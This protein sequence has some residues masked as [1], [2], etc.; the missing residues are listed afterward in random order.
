M[1]GACLIREACSV[2]DIAEACGD[3]GG[4]D[5]VVF[6]VDNV[7][8][9]PADP[10]YQAP[11]LASHAGLFHAIKQTLNPL[12]TDIFL[13]LMITASASIFVEESMVS[14]LNS[15]HRRGIK[16]V[17]LTAA[18]TG[19]LGATSSMETW[20]LNEL[21]RLGIHFDRSFPDQ[22]K[23]LW[24]E[25]PA[26]RG[27]HAVFQEGVLFSNGGN[28][29]TTK[30]ELLVAFLEK[31]AFT[32]SRVVFVDDTLFHLKTVEKALGLSYPHTTYRGLH[33]QKATR[34]CPPKVSAQEFVFKM[35][36]LARQAQDAL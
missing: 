30:G 2:E 34:L 29:T 4:G 14:F 27:Y 6:D 31:M 16:H 19:S 12:Q 33:Y 20:R 28:N 35:G 22:P 11:T 18:L 13:N 5:L 23:V 8:T 26:Y 3:C 24:H 32:P 25:F 15:L 7:L 36:S 21:Q 9:Q 17:A 1:N 10:V